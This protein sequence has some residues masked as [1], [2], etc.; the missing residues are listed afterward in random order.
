[1]YMYSYSCII[2]IIECAAC[3][4][5]ALHA[6]H[7]LLGLHCIACLLACRGAGRGGAEGTER[8]LSSLF[9]FSLLLP[10]ASLAGRRSRSLASNNECGGPDVSSFILVRAARARC[11]RAQRPCASVPHSFTQPSYLGVPHARVLVLVIV[12]GR[13]GS[14]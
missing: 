7:C 10:P 8:W 4:W 6:H 2:I 1:M 13:C 5:C 9:F 14:T 3:G 11:A 12:L